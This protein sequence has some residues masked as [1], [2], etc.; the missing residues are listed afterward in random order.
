MGTMNRTERVVRGDDRRAMPPILFIHGLWHGGWCYEEHFVPWF[1]SRGY[2]AAAVTLRHHDQHHA[3]GLRTTSLKDYVADVVAAAAGMS[4]PP[5][6][7]GHSMGGFVT[8]KY[9]ED[10]DAPAAVLLASA[11][12]QGLLGAT[13]REGAKHPLRLL[14]ATAT[15]SPYGLVKSTERARELFFSGGL[16]DE[17]VRR[18]HAKLTDDSFRVFVEMVLFVRPDLKKIKARGT[19]LL[20]LGGDADR[21]ISR[22]EVTATA[23]FYGA[24]TQS[25]P[26][27][28]HDL[29]L[30]P[31]WEKVAERI[32]SFIRSNTAAKMA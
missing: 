10:H 30:E 29:M 8:Q 27:Q 19:P 24:E 22:S 12:P 16:D 7:V 6:V 11:P 21:S 2:E 15:L 14:A 20:V 17:S 5:V 18:Y 1:G 4:S 13:L 31:D 26:G 9:L 3:P 28:A 23:R 25:F 32:D